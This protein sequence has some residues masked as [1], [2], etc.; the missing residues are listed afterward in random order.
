MSCLLHNLGRRK[1]YTPIKK[2]TFYI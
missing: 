1:L 2:I